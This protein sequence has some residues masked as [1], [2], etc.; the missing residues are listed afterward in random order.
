MNTSWKGTVDV[1]INSKIILTIEYSYA[2]HD[3][4]PAIDYDHV[5]LKSIDISEL[6]ENN[7]F[8]QSKIDEAIIK[9]EQD[10]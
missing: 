2:I 10:N 4:E 1:R 6:I 7:A 3:G 8:V 9:H 5:W